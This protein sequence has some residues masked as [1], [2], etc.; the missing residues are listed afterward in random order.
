MPYREVKQREKALGRP[1]LLAEHVEVIED[2]L[3]T[4]RL[5]FYII[6]GLLIFSMIGGGTIAFYVYGQVQDRAIEVS[7]EQA[8]ARWQRLRQNL[9][10]VTLIRQKSETGQQFRERSQ[11]TLALVAGLFDVDCSDPSK[12]VP[13]PPPDLS[14]R[15]SQ[16]P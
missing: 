2:R 5:R 9:I 4:M 11:R 12:R 7:C 1:L 6:I 16:Q 13:V 8:N 14:T 15:G 10:N 3:W